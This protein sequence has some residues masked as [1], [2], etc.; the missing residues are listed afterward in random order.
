MS[1]FFT[2][3]VSATKGEGP[4]TTRFVYLVSGLMASFCALLMTIGGVL[5]YCAQG[6]AD[7]A[8][9]MAVVSL[10]TVKLGIGG[11]AKTDQQKHT[12]EI[13]VKQINYAVPATASGD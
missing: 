2:Q 10:W 1:S 5:R 4:S 7:S 11:W 9:W 6:T 3:L 12:E 13:A 8:Y